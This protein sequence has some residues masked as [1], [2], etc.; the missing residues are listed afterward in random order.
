M[1]G[2]LGCSSTRVVIAPPAQGLPAELFVLPVSTKV[3]LSR[4]HMET[5]DRLMVA[6]LRNRGFLIARADETEPTTPEQM[7]RTFAR[8]TI[9]TY[10]RQNFLAGHIN[11][12]AGDLMIISSNGESIGDFQAEESDRGGLLFNSGQLFKGLSSA[13]DD[14][15]A[16]NVTPWLKRF[17]ESLARTLPRPSVDGS[18]E[19]LIAPVLQAVKVKQIRSGDF[20]ICATG[21]PGQT[22]HL[23]YAGY[24]TAVREQKQQPGTYCLSLPS[25]VS[26][27]ANGMAEF[28]LSS[29]LGLRAVSSVTLSTQRG[30]C[31]PRPEVRVSSSSTALSFRV[32]C[33]SAQGGPRACG[34]LEGCRSLRF[35]LFQRQQNGA[36]SS[37]KDFGFDG[38]DVAPTTDGQ[39]ITDEFRIITLNDPL[40]FSQELRLQS[41]ANGM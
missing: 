7:Q 2:A 34:E 3:E 1:L 33:L 6:E 11:R 19:K 21:T 15:D 40:G 24:R 41:L 22:A 8:L 12:I 36:F 20:E 13:V 31:E 30:V 17:T 37:S 16:D 25:Y 35:R 29:P 26:T 4:E 38:V 23:L 32:A 9:T 18:R 5:L 28:E 10:A 39:N 27:V 14:F